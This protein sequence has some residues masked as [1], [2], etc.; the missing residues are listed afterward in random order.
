MNQTLTE[1]ELV[2]AAL[3]NFLIPTAELYQPPFLNG[4][5]MDMLETMTPEHAQ[6]PQGRPLVASAPAPPVETLPVP[7]ANRTPKWAPQ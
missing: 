5:L 6:I 1:A 3:L 2:P 7:S 4:D